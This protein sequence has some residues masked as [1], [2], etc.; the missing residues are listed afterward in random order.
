MSA[1]P[2]APIA[3]SLHEDLV[4]HP[5]SDLR[6]SRDDGWMPDS[7]TM[8]NRGVG[9]RTAIVFVHGFAGSAG[10]T[11]EEF[12]SAIRAMP[13]AALTDVFLLD[14][15]STKVSV[16]VCGEEMGAFLADLLRNPMERIVNPSLPDD[17]PPRPIGE[18]YERIVIVAHSMGA[19]VMRRAL[20]DLDRNGMS[21]EEH[22]SLRLLLFAPAHRGSKL[23]KLIASGLG[24]DF[25][26]GSTLIGQALRIHFRSLGDLEEKSQ[27][28]T[29]LFDDSVAARARREARRESDADL[30][31]YVL[32]A[33][34]DKVV[35]QDRFDEDVS[36]RPVG[37][38][39]HRNVCKPEEEYRRPVDEQRPFL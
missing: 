22:H 19:V 11:W 2:A 20:L 12:P 4:H 32:H 14:Y 38:R 5:R 23:S 15:P 30:R 16:Q 10:G 35:V 6:W 29:L 13:E 8:L 17:A 18:R 21:Q 3:L 31:A 27:A 25:L 37:N 24:L 1:A 28:L 33:R 39:D 36:G 26:P 7:Q 34:D 9:I